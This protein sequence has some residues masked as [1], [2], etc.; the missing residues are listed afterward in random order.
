MRASQLVM[1]TLATSEPRAAA[2][3]AFSF[4]C[5]EDFAGVLLTSEHLEPSVPGW[6]YKAD[7]IT[8]RPTFLDFFMCAVGRFI[9]FPSKG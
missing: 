7:T 1:L 6:R 5:K 8:I 9:R 4:L 3:H 2:R